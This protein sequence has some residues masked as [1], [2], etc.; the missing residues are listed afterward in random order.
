MECSLSDSVRLPW[1]LPHQ[2]NHKVVGGDNQFS[3]VISDLFL[4]E[5][6]VSKIA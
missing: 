6:F 3:I 4:C 1:P 5:F 2:G